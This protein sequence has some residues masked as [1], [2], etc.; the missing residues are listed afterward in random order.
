[1]HIYLPQFIIGLDH[2]WR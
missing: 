1:M 2:L